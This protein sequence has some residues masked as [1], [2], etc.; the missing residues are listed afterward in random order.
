MPDLALTILGGAV[1]VLALI[2]IEALAVQLAD[3]RRGERP[4]GEPWR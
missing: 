2:T 3:A 4:S 1:V